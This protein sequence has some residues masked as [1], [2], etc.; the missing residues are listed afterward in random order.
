LDFNRSVTIVPAHDQFGTATITLTVND[1]FLTA[2]TS[3]ILNVV[4]VNDP[5][6]LDPLRNILVERNGGTRTVAL[7][8]IGAGP[9]NERQRVSVLAVSS[10]P[11]LVPNPDVAYNDPEPGATL[12]FTPVAGEVG[13][14]TITVT[15]HDDGGVLDGGEDTFSRT[16]TVEILPTPVLRIS[17]AGETVSISFDTAPDVTYII[18]CKNSAGDSGW[19]T[20]DQVTGTGSAVSVP[21]PIVARSRFYRVR[22]H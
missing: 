3:F 18:E 20:L 14:A 9:R 4:P 2:T 19:I 22:L 13:I 12:A 15:V 11:G 8:G 17:H 5:P 16:F 6:T 21:E 1:G 7:P 10:N